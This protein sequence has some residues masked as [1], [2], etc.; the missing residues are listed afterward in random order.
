M[1]PHGTDT[2][3]RIRGSLVQ[4]EPS[5]A[6]DRQLNADHNWPLDA[7]THS[8]AP[9]RAGSGQ[10]S[11]G[12]AFSARTTCWHQMQ[13]AV[14]VPIRLLCYGVRHSGRAAL[15][16]QL[17]AGS[18]RALGWNVRDRTAPAARYVCTL[19]GVVST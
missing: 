6:L 13:S 3:Q 11:N 15:A 7:C 18:A 10:I 16:R 5:P 8:H 1:A 19:S 12:C 9:G 14:L 17:P 2:R 4:I